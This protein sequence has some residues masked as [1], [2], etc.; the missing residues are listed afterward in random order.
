MSPFDYSD[1]FSPFNLVVDSSIYFAHDPWNVSVGYTGADSF[2]GEMLPC[3]PHDSDDG[4]SSSSQDVTDGLDGLAFMPNDGF[5][6]H[7]NGRFLQDRLN[8]DR[9]IL[10]CSE[11]CHELGQDQFR[12][13]P[14]VGG[15]LEMI[16]QVGD[17][18]S[19]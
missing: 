18:S 7:E 3:S 19:L 5:H 2:P 1:P 12:D 9:G 6:A 17:R 13:M 11:Y 15:P 10:Q 4:Y 14:S 16:Y 8:H